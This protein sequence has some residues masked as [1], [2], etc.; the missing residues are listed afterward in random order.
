MQ[1]LFAIAQAMKTTIMP[2]PWSGDP[3]L[4]IMAGKTPERAEDW[5]PR[6]LLPGLRNMVGASTCEDWPLDLDLKTHPGPG[7]VI[8]PDMYATDD[9]THE[10]Q[11]LSFFQAIMK[12]TGIS[13]PLPQKER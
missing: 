4:K 1:R 2:R 3:A 5:L 8:V 11:Q 13:R 12:S 6:P 10:Q 7:K 9:P